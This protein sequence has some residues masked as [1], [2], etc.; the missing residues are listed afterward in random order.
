MASRTGRAE[1][2]RRA[3]AILLLADGHTWDEARERVPSSRGF[4]PAGRSAL[5]S[6]ASRVFTAGVSGKW[7]ACSPRSWR[8]YSGGDARSTARRG[9]A[10]EHPQAR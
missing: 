3:R 9:D 2:A 4:W 5:P 7:P 8:Q 6:S 10:V 1:D